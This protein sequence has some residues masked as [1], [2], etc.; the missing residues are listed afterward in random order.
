MASSKKASPTWRDVKTSLADF[1]RASLLGLVQDLYAA[2]KENQAFLHSRFGLGHDVLQP[3]IA[4]I[5]RWLWPDVFKSQDTSV[6]KAKKAILDY[7]KAVGHPEGL[8]ELMVLFCERAVGF[9]GDVGLQDEGYLDALVRMFGE[10]LKV[11]DILPAER[12][13]ALLDRLDA[14]RLLSHSLGYGVGD[15][16]DLLLAAS[17]IADRSS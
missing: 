2:S 17:R 1:D 13:P 16:L 7:K 8:S 6:A 9:A 5:D 4:A 3:Y 15:E 10:A 12:R 11:V 14:V